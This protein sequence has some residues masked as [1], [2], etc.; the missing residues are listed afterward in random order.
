[1][2]S[3]K[4]RVKERR[5]LG[6]NFFSVMRATRATLEHP[7]FDPEGFAALEP[8]TLAPVVLE[9]ILR[10]D[11]PEAMADLPKI[12]WDAILA[13]IEKII[14]LILKLLALF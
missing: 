5:E 13:F 12:D 1:M 4:Q 8:A 10:K 2:S 9:E 3:R 7:S 14:P 6:V 11:L